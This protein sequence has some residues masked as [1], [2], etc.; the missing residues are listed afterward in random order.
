MICI[1]GAMFPPPT[2]DYPFPSSSILKKLPAIKDKH[3]NESLRFA[4]MSIDALKRLEKNLEGSRIHAEL[5]SPEHGQLIVGYPSDDANIL[6]QLS[7]TVTK[8]SAYLSHAHC[9]RLVICYRSY[10]KYVVCQYT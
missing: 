9:E 5:G 8:A 3:F 1:I 7:W 2:Y 4:Q 6:Q 10:G